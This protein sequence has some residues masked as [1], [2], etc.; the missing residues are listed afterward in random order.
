MCLHFWL[1]IKKFFEN[2]LS[3]YT[4]KNLPGVSLGGKIANIL[5]L[6]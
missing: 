6:I 2:S 4:K 5:N 1:K 3:G